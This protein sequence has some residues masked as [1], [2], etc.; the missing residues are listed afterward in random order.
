MALIVSSLDLHEARLL[1][2]VTG[3]G[4]DGAPLVFD[5][6]LCAKGRDSTFY[7]TTVAV[8]P[9]VKVKF[10]TVEAA[11]GSPTA[12]SLSLLISTMGMIIQP[13]NLGEGSNETT[14]HSSGMRSGIQ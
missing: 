12:L 7:R 11:L 14:R 1:V 5:L 13:W 9:G 6:G 3:S 2:S 4:E 10:R 8:V